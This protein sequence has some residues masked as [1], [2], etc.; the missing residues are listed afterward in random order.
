MNTAG[1][2]EMLRMPPSLV[3][4]WSLVCFMQDTIRK[5]STKW[6][7]GKMECDSNVTEESKPGIYAPSFD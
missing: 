3:W 7:F 2:P 4:S 1:R 5:M 6:T